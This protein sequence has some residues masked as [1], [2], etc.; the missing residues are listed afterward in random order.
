M[1][2]EFTPWLPQFN[3]LALYRAGDRV[4]AEDA[5]DKAIRA[6]ADDETEF[7]VDIANLY[8]LRGLIFNNP[9]LGAIAKSSAHVERQTV[10]ATWINPDQL[11]ATWPLDMARILLADWKDGTR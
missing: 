3:D 9:N 11:A 7:A 5:A 4:L 6:E 1:G 10:D 8:A 2:V